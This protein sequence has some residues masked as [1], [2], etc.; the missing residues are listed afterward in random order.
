M[1]IRRHQVGRP[2]GG[3]SHPFAAVL[4]AAT[5]LVGIAGA[6]LAA[7]GMPA[8]GVRPA[9]LGNVERPGGVISHGLESGTGVT[10]AIE[11]FNFT[12]EP[13]VFYVYATD[14]IQSTGGGLT[15]APRSAEATDAGTWL[16]SKIDAVEIPARG[17]SLVEFTLDVPPGTT[18]GA[19]GAALLVEP[20]MASEGI[21]NIQARTRV[22]LRVQVE[23]LGDI[24]LGVELGDLS[25]SREGGGI[26]FELTA[27]N[28]GTVTFTADS[29]VTI[30]SGNGDSI[31]GLAME[32]SGLSIAPGDS[33]ALEGLWEDPPIIG[34]YEAQGFVEA[35]VGERLPVR[36][37]T[38]TVTFWM[39]PWVEIILALVV[40]ALIAWVLF[41]TRHRR[42][43]WGRHRREERALLRD[44]RNRRK[45]EEGRATR[46][47]PG[48]RTP[49]H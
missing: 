26:R 47:S 28:T 38:E 31:A 13:T 29:A 39:I 35:V 25:H 18:P 37:P 43:D 1:T 10:D 2:R 14:L 30:S 22:A 36:Y 27:T 49:A 6:S 46:D 20:Q 8:Y 24:D 40:V 3:R 33:V 17:S 9:P 16:K 19:Y 4:I 48:H 12:D 41:V 45:L 15:A 34:K 32:P 21:G 44:Y 11:I 5:L 42:A 7:E 23:V